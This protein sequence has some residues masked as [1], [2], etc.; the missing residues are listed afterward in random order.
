MLNRRNIWAAALSS[1]AIMFAGIANAQQT[2]IPG[3]EEAVAKAAASDWSNSEAQRGGLELVADF[4]SSGPDAWDPAKHPLIY[5]TSESHQNANPDRLIDGSFAGFHIIDAYTKE[6]VKDMIVVESEDNFTVTRGPHGAGLSPDGKW[7]YIGWG[8]QDRT[9]TRGS[10]YIAVVNMRTL[11]VDK[12]FRH[13]QDFRGA[14]RSQQMH[15]VMACATPEGRQRVIFQTGFGANGGPHFVIDPDDDHRV[16][17]AITYTDVQVMGHPFVTASRD[18]STAFVS[19]GSPEARA[20]YTPTAGV[21]KVNIDTGAVDNVMGTGFHPIGIT[22]SH[23]DKFTYV[24][25]GHSSY[26]YKI[27]N[28]VNKVV[29]STSAGVAGPYGIAMNWDESLILTVGKGEGSHNVGRDLGTIDAITFS[30]Y[31]AKKEMPIRLDGTMASVDH[32][33]LHPDPAVNELWISS[34]NGWETAVLDLNTYEV[35][36]Y[37]L[38]PNGGDTHSGAFA[39]YQPDWTGTLMSDQGGPRSPE[40]LSIIEELVVARTPAKPTGPKASPEQ[41]N[42][43]RMLYVQ[44]AAGLGCAPC[45]GMDAV[46]M[47]GPGIRGADRARMD[48]AL[49]RVEEMQFFNDELTEDQLNDIAAFLT[50]LGY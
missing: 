35:K 40:M 7:A 36:D 42:R 1:T 4:D 24:V 34:M 43:G 37:I 23:D 26:V 2:T 32:A 25:D 19:I 49:G 48:D 31:R 16:E 3:Y 14:P 47:S 11:K 46:G 17:R 21:A 9:A 20:N 8:E 27:D 13:E 5:M 30:P 41:I 28:E 15:H 29:G 10:G 39:A 6:V 44:E 33:I 12:I 18:C 38:T 50:S 45:H 22:H